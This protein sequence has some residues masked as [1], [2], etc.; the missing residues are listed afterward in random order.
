MKVSFYI[1]N[2]ST[3]RYELTKLNTI[4]PM[5]TIFV[6]RYGTRW[7]TLPH[8]TTFIEARVECLHKQAD[9]ITGAV[10]KPTPKTRPK[11][12][13]KTL[14]E[15]MDIYLTT[16]KAAEEN[17]R[18]STFK[19]YTQALRLF[20]QSSKKVHLEEITADDLRQFKVFLRAQ[21]TSV[22][23]KID[24]RTVYNHF[25][26]TV[27]YLNT[28]GKRNLVTQAEWP[29]Y[30]KKKVVCYDEGDMRRLLE[31]ATE[32][33]RDVL[34]FFLGA[35]FRNGEG[36]HVEW[37]DIDFKNC[38]VHTYSKLERFSWEVKDTEQ[39]IIGIPDKVMERL[40]ARHERHPG[41]G[42]VLIDS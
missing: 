26:N 3:R 8:G 24:P 40:A 7:E 11:S 34:E 21:K 28:H 36:T 4:Y 29:E 18:K 39:R 31:F 19:A 20:S 33:E 1:R 25:K 30:E 35:G 17:W 42:L 23:K 37:H 27:A 10:A 14:D 2:H 41:N 9:L 12:S 13:V 6:L 22:G 38:E 5:G 15:L 32:D 16:G